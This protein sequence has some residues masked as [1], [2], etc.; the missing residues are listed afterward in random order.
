MPI[1]RNRAS[2]PNKWCIGFP[3]LSF[4]RALKRIRKREGSVRALSTVPAARFSDA[5][6]PMW[7]SQH[8]RGANCHLGLQIDL[9]CV[10]K[11]IRKRPTREE[12]WEVGPWKTSSARILAVNLTH[13]G[14][15]IT[16]F[17][18]DST[19]RCAQCIIFRSARAIFSTKWRASIC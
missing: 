1:L 11:Q 19:R 7:D 17:Y 4:L 14:F 3:F 5:A 9:I 18:G 15:P 6:T 13:R 16:C 12:T 2:S 8:A 10:A